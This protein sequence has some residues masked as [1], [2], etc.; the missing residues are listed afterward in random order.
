MTRSFASVGGSARQ[1]VDLQ[2]EAGPIQDVAAMS[3][4]A[5]F[6]TL[7]AK[8]AL[9]R[10]L[11]AEDDRPGGERVLVLGDE[12]WRGSFGGD[13][14]II[15][16]SIHLGG[17]PWIVV[18]VM[19]PGFA[20]PERSARLYL[21]LWVA[22][23]PGGSDREV[24]F[25]RPVFRLGPGVTPA[26]ARA[27]L[28]AALAELARRHPESDK[29]IEPECVPLLERLVGDSRRV[30]STLVAAVGL[31]LLIACVNLASLQ[32][33]GLR[34]RAPELSIRTALGASRARL[35]RQILIEG[36][37]LALTG[38]ALGFLGSVW[39]VQALLSRFPE[40][41]PRLGSVG[42]NGRVAAFTL[43]ASLATSLVFSLLPAWRAS[44]GRFAGIL[45]DSR[46]AGL[47]RSSRARGTLI[48]TE[49]AVALVLL[50]GAGLLLRVLWELQH[51]PAGLRTEGVL[52]AHIDLPESRYEEKAKQTLFRRR[53]LRGLTAQ[54]GIRA[55][56]VSEIPMSGD[57]LDHKF[58]IDGAP[59]LPPG[60]EPRLYARSVMGDYFGVVGIPLRAGR[61]LAE[62]DREDA[63]YVGVVNESMAR[64]YFPGSNPVGR[65]IRWAVERKP[66]WITIVGVVGDV[67]HFG[68]EESDRPAFY[69]PYVQST[70]PWKRWSEL[71]VRG[72]GGSTGLSEIVR[73]QVRAADPLLPI[74]RIRWMTDVVRDSLSLRRF[75]AE[76]LSLFAASALGLACVGIFGVMWNTVRNR[77]R[78]IGVRIALGAAPARVVRQV[79]FE[80][81]AW[82][83]VGIAIGLPAALGLTRGMAS[84]LIGVKPADPATFA[85]VALL[86]AGAAF[87]T[88]WIPAHRAARIDPLKALRTE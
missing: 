15:G 27:D 45:G 67:R 65:R 34:A 60:D 68:P 57:A 19:P 24:H 42:A 38:G 50:V 18:G 13:P 4:G 63:P 2:T 80:G 58:L 81:L 53:L 55:A 64:L 56:L 86:L 14:G 1:P 30:L 36:L 3:S 72:P 6:E 17:A 49:V 74:A 73:G 75:H 32:L 35:V 51:V 87:V 66:E 5:L 88:C 41:L 33:T 62:S 82:V 25:V 22:Y 11:R 26:A 48:A 12:L 10:T 46:S 39:G 85:A 69:T 7:G 28:A 37:V 16:R 70:A 52:A 54:P 78:E 83:G 9:G 8:A 61:V 40:A 21:P 71:V 79:L 77:R 84:L 20:V 44:S 76:V 47:R 59:S 31:V 29:G 23:P 43:V